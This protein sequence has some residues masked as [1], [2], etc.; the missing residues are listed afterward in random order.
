MQKYV[1]PAAL[2]HGLPQTSLP[3][4]FAAIQSGT[5][6]ALEAVPGM[7][8]QIAQAVGIAIKISYEKTFSVIYLIAMAFG[9]C[10]TI[11]AFLL[12]GSALDNK[13]TTQ[14]ARKLQGIGRQE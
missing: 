2:S 8:V 7:D 13:L 14:V 9:I 10:A 11:A 1:I 12:R 6:S 4:L 3:G 5:A